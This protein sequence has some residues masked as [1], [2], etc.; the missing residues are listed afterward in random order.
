[1]AQGSLLEI[2]FPHSTETPQPVPASLSLMLLVTELFPTL[3]P[4]RAGTWTDW[5]GA[6]PEEV[7][8]GKADF[9]AGRDREKERPGNQPGTEEGFCALQIPRGDCTSQGGPAATGT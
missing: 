7:P 6:G 5:L 1:M 3:A 4:L 2:P 9:T 8:T